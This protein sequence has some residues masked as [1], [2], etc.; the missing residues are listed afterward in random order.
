MARPHVPMRDGMRHRAHGVR[1][2]QTAAMRYA[3]W[4][5]GFE[6]LMPAVHILSLRLIMVARQSCV[7]RAV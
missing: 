6:P 1:A 5:W 4:P 7:R 2:A 3:A